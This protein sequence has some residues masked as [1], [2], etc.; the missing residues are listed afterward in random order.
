EWRAIDRRGREG[1]RIVWHATG[2]PAAVSAD[3]GW[4]QSFQAGA[5]P[6]PPIIRVPFDPRTGRFSDTRDTV[7]TGQVTQFSVTADG[8]T[9]VLDEGTSEYSAWNLELRDA[10]RGTF[11]DEPRLSRST[12]PVFMNIPPD[13]NRVLIF[14]SGGAS[15]G[16]QLTVVPFGGGTEIPLPLSGSPLGAAMDA[17]SDI[18]ALGE[19]T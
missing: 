14:R 1:G 4:A 12:T 3:A 15:A 16:G 8:G 5:N 11:A 13:G 7:Y 18:V 2:G 19:K 6:R 17:D 10:L 9:L